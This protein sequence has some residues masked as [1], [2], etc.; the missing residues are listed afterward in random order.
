MARLP[1]YYALSQ[2][3]A[4][5]VAWQPGIPATLPGNQ[6][7]NTSTIVV[8]LKI[9]RAY[10]GSEIYQGLSVSW[11]LAQLGWRERGASTPR[12]AGSP[13]QTLAANSRRRYQEPSS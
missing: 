4:K 6:P 2:T 11:V 13:S 3:C 8:C 5:F 9:V 12:Q 7:G 1:L 10:Y